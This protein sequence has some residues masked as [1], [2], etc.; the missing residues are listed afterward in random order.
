MR[1]PLL[2]MTL[3]AALSVG[4]MAEPNDLRSEAAA[5]EAIA[6]GVAFLVADQNADGSWGG[7]RDSVYT[8]GGG[9]WSNP[10]AHRSWRVATTGVDVWALTMVDEL[11]AP[12]DEEAVAALHRG[13]EYL[14]ANADLK[15]VSAR[16]T[17]NNWGYL[18]ALHGLSAAA[19]SR[20]FARS[21]IRQQ[22]AEAVGGN[23]DG[24]R[25]WQSLN[26]GWGYL[27]SSP[28]TQTPR[29]SMGFMT[30]AAIL[31]MDEARRAGF[32]I[33]D[34]VFARGVK[35][36]QRCHLPNGAY[37]Y[38]VMTIP[39]RHRSNSINDVKG[40][41]TRIAISDLARLAGGETLREEDLLWGLEQF[42]EHHRFVEI[43]LYRRYPH[44]VFYQNS[45]YFYLFGQCYSAMLIE[46]MP[47]D[48]QAQM[49]PRLREQVIRTQGADGAMWDYVMLAYHKPYGTGYGLIALAH[50]LPGTR[51][52]PPTTQP[53]R[54]EFDAMFGD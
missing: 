20:H 44:E 14:V 35:A 21:P 36:V 6:R 15:R 49:W 33:D 4:A 47:A 17:W 19:N 32:T 8:F 26:G 28:A 9:V 27:E 46:R 22:I 43:A 24:L 18:Y 42:F 53:A 23:L 3:C 38:T 48:V 51:P 25:A 52:P 7:P 34:E 30:A 41:L 12:L 45:G 40:S 37:S 11:A 50:S 13:V 5:R 10:E 2:I 39:H 1:Q 54:P 31:A 29:R 16:E